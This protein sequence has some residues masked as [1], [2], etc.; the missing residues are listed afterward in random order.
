[1]HKEVEVIKSKL[2]K[3]PDKKK[4]FMLCGEPVQAVAQ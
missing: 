2:I 4:K 1:M 3:Y